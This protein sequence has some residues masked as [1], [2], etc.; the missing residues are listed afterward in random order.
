MTSFSL[1]VAL[2][3]SLL[4][5]II[6]NNIIAIVLVSFAS[7]IG[8]T[9]AFLMSRYFLRDYCSTRYANQY[10]NINNGISKHGAS[11][12]FATRMIPVFPF[13]II[14]ILSGLTTLTAK[15][16]FFISQVA[17]LPMT[18]IIILIGD[19]I[20]KIIINEINIGLELLILMSVFGLIPILSRL[21][22]NKYF[23]Q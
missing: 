19:N 10:K 18:I 20:G 17:M 9:L 15:K 23:R 12:L 5:G 21:F 2:I 22:F 4:A 13:F 6:F 11:Y 16:F 3:M 14:N 1:P 7:T 8:A